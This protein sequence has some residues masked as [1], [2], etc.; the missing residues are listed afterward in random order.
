MELE[1]VKYN[2][3]K[4]TDYYYI[5]PKNEK[6]SKEIQKFLLSNGFQWRG[7]EKWIPSRIIKRY[8]IYFNMQFFIMYDSF[9]PKYTVDALNLDFKVLKSGLL[10]NK[11][12]EFINDLFKEI[13]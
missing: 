1:K 6:Q 10:K 2:L 4:G 13:I 8:K 7:N 5:V 9:V 12:K 3:K 11:N